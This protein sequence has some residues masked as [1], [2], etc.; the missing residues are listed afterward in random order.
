ML[1]KV[2]FTQK[3]EVDFLIAQNEC[4]KTSLPYYPILKM[5]I[6]TFFALTVLIDFYIIQ[7]GFKVLITAECSNRIVVTQKFIISP[8]SNT[9]QNI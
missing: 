8:I 3:V 6:L 1:L 5:K 2:P 4:R 7:L 9:D